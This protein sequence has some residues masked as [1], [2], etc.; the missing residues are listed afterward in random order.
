MEEYMTKTRDDYGS[1][2]ARPKFDEKA[3]VLEIADLS[4][5]PDVTEDQLMLRIFPISLTGDG[6]GMNHLIRLLL[7]K[8]LKE[9]F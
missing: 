7:R 9:I 1:R 8:F 2:I 3:R 5:I 4:T 6:L